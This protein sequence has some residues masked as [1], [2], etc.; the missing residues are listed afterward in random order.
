MSKYIDAEKLKT[1]ID[2]IIEMAEERWDNEQVTGVKKLNKIW[3][4]FQMIIIHSTNFTITGCFTM[5]HS[6][7]FC[8][9]RWFTSLK[10]II[11]E[12]NVSEEVGSL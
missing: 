3:V 12:K 11:V 6:S 2:D 10:G 5:L 8:Q 9:K 1:E 4:R 7:I